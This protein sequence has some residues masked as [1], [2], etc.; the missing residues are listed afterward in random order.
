MGYN[1]C[2]CGNRKASHGKQCREC[3]AID[4]PTPNVISPAEAA[5]IAGII[6]GEGCF[7]PSGDRGAWSICVVMTDQDVIQRLHDLTG[8]GS[9]YTMREAD[10]TRKKAWQWGIYNRPHPRMAGGPNVALALCASSCEG[11]RATG[12]F[13]RHRVGRLIHRSDTPIDGV[14]LPGC[15]P[16]PL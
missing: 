11:R 9:I 8:I 10:N 14:R 1:K 2:A 15:R 4:Y 3:R 6:E 13:E 16:M 12:R 7:S 5:W